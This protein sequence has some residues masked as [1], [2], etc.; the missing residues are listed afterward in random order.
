MKYVGNWRSKLSRSKIVFSFA[1]QTYANPIT[2]MHAGGG[3]S[4]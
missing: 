1:T 3:K 4:C 2:F